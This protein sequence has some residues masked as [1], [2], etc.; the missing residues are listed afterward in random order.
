MS[1]SCSEMWGIT[2]ILNHMCPSPPSSYK[3]DRYQ[4]VLPGDVA[5]LDSCKDQLFAFPVSSR[6]T[7]AVCVSDL[8]APCSWAGR[9]LGIFMD[10]LLQRSALGFTPLTSSRTP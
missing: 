5:F 3:F 6:R 2:S 7:R 9:K 10:R 4:F 8:Y 1:T